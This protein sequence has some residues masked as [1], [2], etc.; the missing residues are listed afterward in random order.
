[1]RLRHI[2]CIVALLLA[3]CAPEELPVEP[4]PRVLVDVEEMNISFRFH[5]PLTLRVSSNEALLSG[6]STRIQVQTVEY[7][8]VRPPE[9]TAVEV[10]HWAIPADIAKRVSDGRTCEPLKTSA[11][12][13][14]INT[15]LPVQCDMIIDVAGR[16]VIWMVG[17]GRPFQDVPFLQSS[18][19]VL[20][21]EQ[22]HVFSYVYSFSESDATVQWLHDSFTDRHPNMSTLRWP[23][24]SFMLLTEEVHGALAKKIDPPSDEVQSVMAQ[25]R[26]LA[27]SVGLPTGQ[28]GPSPALLGQ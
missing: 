4:D 18:F 25:L 19:I 21:D 17:V 7:G 15:L 14:P 2:P 8:D 6:A 28:A 5:E 9:T 27:F 11:V 16:S 20:E 12:L 13:L 1:M 3:G 23:N 24:K 22:F 26:A 10:L